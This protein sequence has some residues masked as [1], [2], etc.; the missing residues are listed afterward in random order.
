VNSVT[1]ESAECLVPKHL[2]IRG[3]RICQ[4][5]SGKRGVGGNCWLDCELLFWVLACMIM[6]LPLLLASVTL[7]LV[8]IDRGDL[9]L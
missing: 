3:V 2:I 5:S 8:V 4:A 1:D 6:L 7:N 9:K